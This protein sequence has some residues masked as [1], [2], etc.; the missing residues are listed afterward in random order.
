MNSNF[1][2]NYVFEENLEAEFSIIDGIFT[3]NNEQIILQHVNAIQNLKTLDTYTDIIIGE[4]DNNYFE[5]TYRYSSDANN[6]SNWLPLNNGEFDGFPSEY[7]NDLIWIQIRYVFVSDNTKEVEFNNFKFYGTRTIDEIFEPAILEPG[8]PVVYTNQDTYKVYDLEDFA[9]YIDDNSSINDLDIKFR[10]TQTQG[11]RWTDWINLTADNLKELKLEKV[12][13]AN[14][15]FSFHNTGTNNIQLFDLEL[16]GEFQ[17]IT[18]D[19]KTTAK[20]GLKSQCNPLAVKPAPG[21]CIENDDK[22]CLP[23]S[24]AIT[25]WNSDIAN[26]TVCGDNAYINLND[27]ELMNPLIQLNDQLNDFVNNV[28]SWKAT[29]LLTDADGKGIDHVLHE[30]QIHNVIAKKDINIIIPDNQFPTGN[31]SF[32]GFDLDLIQTFEV[33]IVKAHFK[34]IFGLEFRPGK[35][36]VIYICDV[37]ELWEVE[38][39]FPAKSFMNAKFYYRVILKKFNQNSSRDYANTQDGQDAKTFIEQLTNHTTL[40]TMFFSDVDDE[41]K[42]VT[43]DNKANINNASQQ[44]TP[45]TDMNIRNNIDDVVNIIED[46]VYNASLKVVKSYYEMPIK[47]KGM[48][49]VEYNNKDNK[50]NSGQNRALSLWFKTQDYDPTYDYTLLSNYDY[51]NNLGY[52]LSM[53]QG[54]L[55]FTW[56]GNTY[57]LPIAQKMENDIWYS[58]LIN[59]NQNKE[60][61][62]LAVYKRQNENGILLN[63]SK[64]ILVQKINY[65]I[66]ASSFEH[67]ESIF[68]GGTDTFNIQ[69][70]NN[71]WYISNIRIYNEIVNNRHVVLNENVVSDADLTELVD[72]AR[73]KIDLP[74]Y[75]NL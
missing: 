61:C 4:D 51:T 65:T 53:F 68:I 11:R 49:L 47:S 37:N 54:S 48:K 2:I 57:N 72:N 5:K 73:K 66:Q 27:R 9:V 6:W 8:K 23:L 42:K 60:K 35:R 13:F 12:K 71:K 36:D 3:T 63:S 24:E 50:V 29:Y 45:S 32:N 52:K 38:H 26:C 14:F 64:L 74:N 22:T 46:I 1:S 59:Y 62:E 58:I 44:N 25:P 16:F 39:Q 21:D 7:T 10:V 34:K 17:N 55:D 30:Q 18:A 20:Y 33:H 67:D 31:V 19:Y 40:D 43:K 75:G 28:N 15:Q 69:G 41:V 56:N 70:N